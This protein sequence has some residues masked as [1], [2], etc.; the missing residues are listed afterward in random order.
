M[1][2]F[3]H[4]A[5]ILVCILV[6]QSAFAGSGVMA[7]VLGTVNGNTLKVQLR[8]QETMLRL[9]GIATPD[10]NDSTKPILKK[11]GLEAMEFLREYVKS[12]WVYVEFPTGSPVADKDGV[13]DGFV[14]GGKQSEFINEQ[15]IAEGFGVVNRKVQSAFRDNLIKV[16]AKAKASQRGIWG[17]FGAGGGKDVAAGNSHQ[18][19]YMGEAAPQNGSVEYVTFWIISFY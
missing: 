8:G 10:P 6:S 3:I 14:Y 19:T 18:G 4:A 9:Y 17:S 1:R 5:A 12:G 7:K 2:R 15:L 13:V 11:L 16:E